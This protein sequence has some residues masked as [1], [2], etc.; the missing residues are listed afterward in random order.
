MSKSEIEIANTLASFDVLVFSTSGSLTAL[1]AQT[2][3]RSLRSLRSAFSRVLPFLSVSWSLT[4]DYSDRR[5]TRGS[6][7]A[8]RLAGT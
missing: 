5:A 3:S 2:V 4:F 6:T 7:R 1:R 8:A